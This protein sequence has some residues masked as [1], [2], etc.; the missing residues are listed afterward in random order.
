M[1]NAFENMAPCM[2]NYMTD[3]SHGVVEDAAETVEFT[4]VREWSL[5]V[6]Y[7]YT[8]GVLFHIWWCITKPLSSSITL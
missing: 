6:L 1:E 3:L 2:F 7:L 8:V 5:R 4:V